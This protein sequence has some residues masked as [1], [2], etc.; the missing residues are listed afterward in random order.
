[1]NPAITIERAALELALESRLESTEAEKVRAWPKALDQ[2]AM[3]NAVEQWEERLL[4]AARR[5]ELIA[6]D[7]HTLL[8]VEEKRTG[9]KKVDLIAW[10]LGKT[11]IPPDEL[12]ARPYY[13]VI[14]VADINAWLELKGSPYKITT[15]DDDAIQSAPD[16]AR[17][18]VLAWADALF[19]ELLKSGHRV[20]S[21]KKMAS[22]LYKRGKLK[23]Q[24]SDGEALMTE[25]TIYDHLCKSG[26]LE[27]WTP[28]KKP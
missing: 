26:T 7:P 17:K 18:T 8:P 13:H 25:A 9:H 6:R 10:N 27:G 2:G 16:S 12:N 19:Y 4:N 23:E 28:P 15:A 14:Y 3:E 5:G 24:R 22:L 20:V 21:K 1:M 11:E